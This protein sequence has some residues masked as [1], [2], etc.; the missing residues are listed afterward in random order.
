MD[1]PDGETV[2][3]GGIIL[4]KFADVKFTAEFSAHAKADEMIE[5]LKKFKNLNAVLVNHGETETKEIFAKRIVHETNAKNVAI[6]NREY[7]FRISPWGIV[8]SI[9]TEF[10]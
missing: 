6:L 9:P 7:L 3:V 8:K 5:F 2:K 1:T 4:R 10:M